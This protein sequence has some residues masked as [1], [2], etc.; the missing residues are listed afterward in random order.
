MRKPRELVTSYSK[1]QSGQE[2][3][4]HV[5]DERGYAGKWSP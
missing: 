4:E 5:N 2:A 3:I 1:S